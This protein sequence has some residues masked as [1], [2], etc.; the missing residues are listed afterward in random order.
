MSKYEEEHGAAGARSECI[1]TKREH[2]GFWLFHDW[3]IRPVMVQEVIS[4][5]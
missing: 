1:C 5:K 4:K 3:L 2:L